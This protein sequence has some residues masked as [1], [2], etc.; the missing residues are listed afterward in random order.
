MGNIGSEHELDGEHLSLEMHIVSLNLD[1]STQNDFKAAVTGVL[2]ERD[3]SSS[4]DN[5]ADIFL[6]T[7]LTTD[8]ELDLMTDFINY[9]NF[10]HRYSYRGSL[11][12]PPYSES[13]LWNVLADPVKVK[14]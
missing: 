9:L 2:F 11:T 7:L 4:K 10:N 8:K 6:K 5:F 14:S 13:L 12:T 3:D 1:L